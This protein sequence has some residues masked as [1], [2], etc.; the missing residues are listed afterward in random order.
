MG[1]EMCIRDRRMM[2]PDCDTDRLLTDFPNI[3]A[4][5]VTALFEDIARVFPDK[6]PG[7][8]LRRNP[9]IAYQVCL[10]HHTPAHT[11]ECD[12]TL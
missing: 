10:K 6:S 9:K 11:P 5:D 8:V 2:P 3:L 7:D 12:E 1:S 4:M